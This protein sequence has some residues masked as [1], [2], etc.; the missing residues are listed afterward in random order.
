MIR[1]IFLISIITLF[2]NVV[3]AQYVYK[4]ELPTVNGIEIKYKVIHSKLFDKTS[5]VQLRIKLKNTND[6]DASI[7]LQ[8][9]YSTGFT[10][11]FRSENFDI[12][13][14]KNSVRKGKVNGL[15]FELNSSDKD[16]F[17]SEDTEWEFV[18]FEVEQV[19]V[20]GGKNQ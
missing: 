8:V 20:C 3:F 5:P 17:L 13:I 6:F 11:K 2:C 10:Q 14:P 18:K 15:V 12:C 4:N 16:I 1:K 7:N 19:D 9:E